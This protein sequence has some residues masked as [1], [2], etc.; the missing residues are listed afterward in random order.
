MKGDRLPFLRTLRNRLRDR[1]F[2]FLRH[3]AAIDDS[4]QILSGWLQLH[5]ALPF[6]KELSDVQLGAPPYPELRRIPTAEE[7]RSRSDIVFITGRFRSGSTLLWN[8]FRNIPSVTAY[9]EPFNERR[10]FDRKVRGSHVDS[11]HLNVTDYWSE[12]DGLELL[13]EHFQ[14]QW[15]FRHLYM[16]ADAWNAAMQRY[17]EILVERATG[18]PVLQFNEVDFRLPWLRARFPN[19]KIIHIYRHPRDQWR[20]TL[21]SHDVDMKS[22]RLRD[23]EP[24]D[25]FYLLSWGRDLRHYFPF[26]TLDEDSHPYELF[27]QIWKLSYIFGRVYSHVSLSY[28][29]TVERPAHSI[30]TIL[31]GALINYDAEKLAGLVSR[32][33]FGRWKRYASDALFSS[34]EQRVDETF[35]TY[36]GDIKRQ[37]PASVSIRSA[38]G[39]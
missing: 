35:G 15:K 7:T 36:F 1:F 20:S 9:Y 25:G 33:P 28:E 31:A 4:R 37:S 6:P 39:A 23:F 5:N 14:E 3:V 2:R 17:I 13:G 12:Y 32:V 11:T 19:A 16:T 27:Y 38:V 24:L 8:I 21:G 10:W 30:R 22:L 26:L 34:I 18:S 29:E